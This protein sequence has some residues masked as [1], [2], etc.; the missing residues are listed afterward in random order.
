MTQATKTLH[1]SII[2]CLKGILAAWEKWLDEKS[3]GV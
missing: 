1:L 2:R 3:A